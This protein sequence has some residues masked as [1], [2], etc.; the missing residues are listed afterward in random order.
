MLESF[1]ERA[2]W[3]AEVVLGLGLLI[4]LHEL[5][6]YIMAKR[7]KVRVE[8]FSLGFGKP[9]FSWRRGETEYRI[10]MIP[11]GGYV[12]MAGEAITDERRGEPWEL[13]S[14]TAWQRFQIFTA[15]AVM[16]LLVG[17][18]LAILTFLVGQYEFSNEV[19]V[20]GVPESLAG[21]QPG[22]VIVRA[23]DR[24]I[25]NMNKYRIE[26]V[27]RPNGSVVPVTVLRDG[28]EVTFQVE[29]RRSI[30]HHRTQPPSLLLGYVQ[31]GSPAEA[32]GLREMDEV[33][34]AD[35]RR[36][37]TWRQLDEIV[38][39]SPGKPLRIKVRRRDDR[40]NA[41]IH[42]AV[43]TPPPKESYALPEDA[44]IFECVV[45]QVVNG[46]PAWDKLQPGD[47]IV[48]LD[49]RE[50]QSWQ[51]LKDVVEGAVNRPIRFFVSRGGKTLEQPVEITPTYG[52]SGNG[53]I[54]ISQ[55]GTRVFAFVAPGSFFERAG[56]RSG[57]ELY[58]IPRRNKEGGWQEDV[59][60]EQDSDLPLMN[61][62]AFR[63]KEP[64]ILGIQV[65]RGAQKV[66][67]DL[68]LE[69]RVEGDAAALGLSRG[70]LLALDLSRAFRRRPFMEAVAAGLHEP[71]DV[72][73]MT[74]EV[75]GKLISMQES[76][77]GLAGPVGIFHVS[78][79]SVELS[80]GNFLWLLCL[81]TVN[82]GIFNLLPIPILD[83]GHLVL[84]LIEKLR[85]KP[86]AEKFIAAFQYS[87]LLFILALIV[88]VTY[89]DISRFFGGG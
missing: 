45:G 10:S 60:G 18:P 67:I 24:K 28:R 84:L 53:A 21:M 39:K 33:V 27:R 29:T 63:E 3:I 64:H 83:G 34:E 7:H 87:G 8:A 41:S 42:E 81:I 44:R 69:K 79:K 86:P 15:G 52:D 23:G 89:N 56:L 57:D 75:I 13:T 71:F 4:F 17:F 47:R 14:K 5:G 11:I 88:F 48:R 62:F 73:V 16:N 31:P 68:P 51:D 9:I 65:K 36:L 26:M 82:L 78:M 38:R 1:F 12:K 70:G 32:A 85:G 66:K 30:W 37:Y 54:G 2:V 61:L 46:L 74:F 35:G 25:E 55:K 6:H 50:V 40:W 43:V 59:T 49:D 77:R 19:G 22:D 76:V 58:S 80:F 20:P 72:G